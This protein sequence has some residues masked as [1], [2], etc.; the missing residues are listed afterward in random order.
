[1]VTLWEKVKKCLADGVEVLKEG[2]SIVAE[3]S[4]ELAKIGKIKVEII[5]LNRKI[6]NC[7]NEIG[8]RFYHLKIEDKQEEIN[9]DNKINELVEEI[10]KIEEKVKD[11]EEQIDKLKNKA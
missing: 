1:M 6:N 5:N 3:K 9:N 4:S 7:F 8:G 11:K 2:T 10:K